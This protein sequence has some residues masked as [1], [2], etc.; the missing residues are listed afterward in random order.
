M[1]RTGRLK[2]EGLSFYH[3]MNRITMKQRFIEEYG[4]KEMLLDSIRRAAEFS[5]VKIYAFAIMDNH[6]HIL[7]E[8]GREEGSP[9]IP[10]EELL[11]RV[12]ILKGERA[13]E[14]MA[15]QW[16]FWR[17]NNKAYKADDEIFRLRR[18]IGD[19]SEFVKTYTEMFSQRIRR[20][21]KYVGVLWQNRFKSVLIQDGSQFQ[22]VL[23]YINNNPVRAKYTKTSQE[24]AWCT[25]GA[26]NLREQP[27]RAFAKQCK[28]NVESLKSAGDSPQISVAE[29]EYI[30]EITNAKILGNEEFVMKYG[31]IRP[32]CFG[33]RGVQVHKVAEG[34][35]AAGGSRLGKSNRFAK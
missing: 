24:Y 1:A 15:E 5:G 4:V 26:H 14:D 13:A 30:A 28:D 21:K 18:R 7:C 27:L 8:V 33:S 17:N 31:G 6:Y 11:R 3:V 16:K 19:L 10:E 32:D 23:R 29:G 25:L 35:Y 22:T 20:E 34:I 2:M 12:A 9:E